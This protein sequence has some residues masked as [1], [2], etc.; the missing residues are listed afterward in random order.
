MHF[1]YSSVLEPE[2]RF[3]Y[4][5]C[6]EAAQGLWDN[7]T[8][9]HLRESDSSRGYSIIHRNQQTSVLSDVLSPAIWLLSKNVSLFQMFVL[10]L[11]L[12]VSAGRTILAL[13]FTYLTP[14]KLVYYQCPTTLGNTSLYKP[15]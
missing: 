12:T 11:N 1:Y 10:G 14:P 2:K 9:N 4:C 6:L 8:I 13:V 5:H 3:G 7:I 15:A